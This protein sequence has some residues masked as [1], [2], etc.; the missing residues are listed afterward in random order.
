MAANFREKVNEIKFPE[1]RAAEIENALKDHITVN[2]DEDPEYYKS[3]SL[4]LR[5]IIEKNAG[6]WEQQ[7]LLLLEMLGDVKSDRGKVAEA[8]GLSELELPFYNIM[9][10]EVAGDDGEDLVDQTTLD[11]IRNTTKALVQMFD[12]AS[13][14]VDL[15]NK[16]DQ[17]KTMKKNIKRTVIDQPFGNAQLVSALQ[18]RFI[19]LAKTKFRNN[20]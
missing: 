7:E 15:F 11:A 12:E 8:L 2:L 6:K 4:R 10:S 18:Q 19:E 16:P 5:D 3:L 14:I 9:L 13:T 17:I 20:S 1:S